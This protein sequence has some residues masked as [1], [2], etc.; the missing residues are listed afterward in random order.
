MKNLIIIGIC[1]FS[2]LAF[3]Q[4][5]LF[6]SIPSADSFLIKAKSE[7]ETNPN[8]RFCHEYGG[9]YGEVELFCNNT[10]YNCMEHENLYTLKQY[11]LEESRLSEECIKSLEIKKIYKN[12]KLA[13]YYVTS[14][15]NPGC[16]V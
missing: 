10:K 4:N 11:I 6:K 13:N 14:V 7:C 15:L 8:Y 9:A 1:I 5:K 12:G 3:A 2:P 16:E